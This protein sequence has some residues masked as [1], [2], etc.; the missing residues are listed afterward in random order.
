M[1]TMFKIALLADDLKMRKL[2]A[3]ILTRTMIQMLNRNNVI[4]YLTPAHLRL[5]RK[6]NEYRTEKV[7]V[8]IKKQKQRKKKQ[9]RQNNSNSVS[10]SSSVN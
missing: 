8:S 2:Q 7:E 1:D 10:E 9:K 4:H 6:H 3:E 5:Q